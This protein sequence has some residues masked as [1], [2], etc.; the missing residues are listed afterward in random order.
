M[1]PIFIKAG[2]RRPDLV[3]VPIMR[4]IWD[5]LQPP[6]IAAAEQPATKV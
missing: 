1:L 5:P 2:E 4:L 6:N 3:G